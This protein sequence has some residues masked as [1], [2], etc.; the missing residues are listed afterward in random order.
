MCIRKVSRDHPRYLDHR[1]GAETRPFTPASVELPEPSP[2]GLVAV[3]PAAASSSVSAAIAV[4]YRWRMITA[5]A[6]P[7]ASTAAT[8]KDQVSGEEV[9]FWGVSSSTLICRAAVRSA[10]ETLGARV[11]VV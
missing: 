3:V 7:A 2:A 1:P 9:R 10:S 5:T 4:R 6:P 11:L 8:R